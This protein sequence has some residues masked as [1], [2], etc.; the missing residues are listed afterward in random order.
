MLIVFHPFL[1]EVLAGE[2]DFDE[3]IQKLEKETTV[4][5]FNMLDYYLNEENLDSN[6][7]ESY[8]WPLDQH[9]NEAGYALFAR[10]V[11]QKIEE[12]NRGD[13]SRSEN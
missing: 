6:S 4:D 8:Y 1:S 3:V 9:H 12:L 2:F 13:K 11:Q 5:V 7:I 10:G